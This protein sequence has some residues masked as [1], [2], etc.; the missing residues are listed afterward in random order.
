MDLQA[1]QSRIRRALGRLAEDLPMRWTPASQLHLTL[2]FLGPASPERI[3]GLGTSLRKALR[4]REPARVEVGGLG[5]FPSVRPP[6][7]LWLGVRPDAALL[8][9]RATLHRMAEADAIAP[10]GR[11][12]FPHITLAKIRPAATSP[13]TRPTLHAM[14][15]ATSRQGIALNRE[16]RV[17][18][19]DLMA[20]DPAPGG[21]RHAVI[22]RFPL[23]HANPA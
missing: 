15:E 23:G 6:R 17:S 1:I 18:S 2:V 16:W 5:C 21:H 20:S 12:F 19:V 10:D 9:L 13:A 22:E 8:A 3:D 4:Q 7:V 11:A 14:L